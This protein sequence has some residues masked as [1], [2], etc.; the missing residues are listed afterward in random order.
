MVREIAFLVIMM[1]S[2]VS[3]NHSKNIQ[4]TESNEKPKYLWF[5]AEANYKRFASKDS[6]SFY[7]DKAKQTGF[8]QIVVDVRPV[9]GDVLYD[10][11]F[12]PLLTESDGFKAERNWDYLQFFIDEAHKRSLKVT[13]STTIFPIGI[14]LNKAGMAFRDATWDGK[15]CVEYTKDG[16]LIDI[17]NDVSKV[18]VFLNPVLPETQAFALKFIKEIVTKYDFDGYALDYCRYPGDESDFSEASRLA[19]EKYIGQKVQNFPSDIFTWNV[20]GTK[21]PGILYKQWWEFRS[22]VIHDFIKKVRAEI[23]SIKPSVKLEYWAP[24]WIDSL[25]G[26]GQNWAN[27]SYDPSIKKFGWASSNYKNTG[28]AEHLDVFLCGTYLNEIYGKDN[29]ESIEFGI[30]KGNRVVGNACAVFGTIYALNHK[31]NAE[32]AVYVCLSQSAGLMVFDIVQVIGFDLW[33]SIKK[34]IEKAESES[35]N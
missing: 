13:V 7:L 10:S 15:T 26:Q 3:C 19:F 35:N 31:T 20:D 30:A 27:K 29:P 21:T 23:Q 14:P 17:K 8:N 34:G 2:L 6:I 4:E 24:S 32:D 33:D 11:D 9:Q 12:M 22:M 5:D 18:A 1:C 25:Y 28:F 16:T